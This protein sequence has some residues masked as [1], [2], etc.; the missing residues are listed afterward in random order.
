MREIKLTATL[1]GLD[2][3][4]GRDRPLLGN[5]VHFGLRD[6]V[7]ASFKTLC[8]IVFRV[9]SPVGSTNALSNTSKARRLKLSAIGEAIW[10]YRK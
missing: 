1:N 4:F 7:D 2:E 8:F 10:S 3:V 9:G 5:F 6:K